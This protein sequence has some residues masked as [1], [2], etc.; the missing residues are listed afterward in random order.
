VGLGVRQSIVSQRV[1]C[2]G[3]ADKFAGIWELHAPDQPEG[4]RQSQIHAA[5]MRTGKS[6]AADV[7]ETV[8]RAL[9]GY[10]QSWSRMYQQNCEA[11]HIRHEQSEEVLDLRTSCLQE[12]LAG[13]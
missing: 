13:F 5:F 10:A 1:M 12:R 3:G 7:Y 9:T 4:Q 11:T 8:T 6:Y 2:G